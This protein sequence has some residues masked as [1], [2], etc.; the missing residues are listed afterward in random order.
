MLRQIRRLAAVVVFASAV[1]V[2]VQPTMAGP[3]DY[4]YGCYIVSEPYCWGNYLQN[5]TF[6][7]CLEN[8]EV[9]SACDSADLFCDQ[10]CSSYAGVW[11]DDW[12]GYATICAPD[13]GVGPEHSGECSCYEQPSTCDSYCYAYYNQPP[14]CS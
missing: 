4:P 1:Y 7:G 2:Q 5:A 6:D 13:G 11:G 14:F 3:G 12:G 8:P 9:W 10:W